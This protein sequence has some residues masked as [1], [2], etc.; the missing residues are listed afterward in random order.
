MIT[1]EEFRRRWGEEEF[2]HFPPDVVHRLNIPEEAR[3]FLLQA[4]LPRQ[5]EPFFVFDVGHNTLPT[6][7]E[8]L[9]SYNLPLDYARYRLIAEKQHRWSDEINITH[10]ICLDKQANGQVIWVLNDEDYPASLLNTSLLH[11]AEMLLI[12]REHRQWI[13]SLG[14]WNPIF[15]SD[16]WD[17]RQLDTASVLRKVDPEALLHEQ[18]WYWIIVDVETT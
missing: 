10:F 6:L 3:Q 18:G 2:V 12:Y 16:E 8:Y 5:A 4:G 17:Q 15:N 1:P 9:S 13:Y 11:L 14:T 7:P